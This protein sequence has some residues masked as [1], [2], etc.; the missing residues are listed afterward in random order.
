METS[1][2]RIEEFLQTKVQHV[3]ETTHH[4]MNQFHLRNRAEKHRLQK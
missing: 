4:G 3:S 2:I 1:A